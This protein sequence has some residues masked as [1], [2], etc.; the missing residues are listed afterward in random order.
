MNSITTSALPR[1]RLLSA[2]ESAA[3]W[4]VSATQK[5]QDFWTLPPSE[6]TLHC[7]SYASPRP[8]GDEAVSKKIHDWNRN[9][10]AARK[11]IAQV[12]EI[13]PPGSLRDSDV[14]GVVNLVLWHCARLAFFSRPGR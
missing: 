2:N 4:L 1:V 9:V 8:K 11:A 14:P 5:N 13:L 12:V 7:L 10:T 3:V 6:L